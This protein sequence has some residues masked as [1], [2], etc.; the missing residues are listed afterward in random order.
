MTQRIFISRKLPDEVIAPL[1]ENY[2][3]KM[4]DKEDRPIPYE[5]L[6]KEVKDADAL[7]TM[8]SENVN[9]ELLT[10]GN[11]LKI[12]AN[13]AVGYDNVDIS[14]AKDLGITITNTPDVLTES[15]ADL[16]FALLLATARRMIEASEYVK[17]GDWKSWSPLLLAGH[18]VHRKTIGIVGM[19]SIGK[20]VAKRATG[21]DMNILYY[22]RSRKQDAED[23][24]G[25]KYVDF[26]ELL[27]QS[28]FIVCLTPLTE[29]TKDM[30]TREAFKK[31]KQT[32]VFVNASRGPVVNEK[33]LYDAL[34]SGEI[35]GAGL[36]VFVN[37]PI[38][39]DH[40]LLKLK[41]VV[42]MPHI[43]SATG[44]TRNK[45]MKLCVE[46]IEAVLSNKKAITPV[47]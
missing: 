43:G 41:Q 20:V 10:A 16:A 21:F 7:L 45:M 34:V 32:A 8:L 42:A 26:D 19:G 14:S 23:E 46:N 9:K 11:K 44:E 18:D 28:D 36:D 15:T 12:V 27:A 40:P 35:A 17:N 2:D 4:W 13:M 22:N 5:E 47:F 33:D 31:M 39:A 1:K 25:A 37:E 30:F 38:D 3:V 24:L 6:V 29:E